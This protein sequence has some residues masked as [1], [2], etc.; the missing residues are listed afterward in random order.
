M[1]SLKLLV[2][3]ELAALQL[4]PPLVVLK[5]PPSVPA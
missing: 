3:P 4:A 2:M 5:T 1:R